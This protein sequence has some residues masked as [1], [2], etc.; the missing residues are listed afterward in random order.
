MNTQ[1]L[2]RVFFFTEKKFHYHTYNKHFILL[3][4][5][6][7]RRLLPPREEPGDGGHPA[8]SAGCIRSDETVDHLPDGGVPPVERI[9]VHLGVLEGEKDPLEVEG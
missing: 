5:E 7:E 1:I 2:S 4:V 9:G 8:V 3:L 6:N